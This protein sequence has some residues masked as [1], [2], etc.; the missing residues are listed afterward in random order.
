MRACI[1]VSVASNIPGG[2]PAWLTPASAA[3]GIV[4]QVIILRFQFRHARASCL[5]A[6]LTACILT[7]CILTA[8]ILTAFSLHAF[9]LHSH[10]ICILTAFSLHMHSPLTA[11]V[12]LSLHAFSLHAFSLHSH[13]MHSHCILTAYAFSSHCLRAPLTACILL[14]L[15]ACSSHCVHLLTLPWLVASARLPLKCLNVF[16]HVRACGL[17]SVHESW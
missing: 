8:C 6:P 11:C 7:A 2:T 9:S 5:R 15:P 12:L 1:L 13:C 4:L 10:C 16:W 14:S 17:W 3:T